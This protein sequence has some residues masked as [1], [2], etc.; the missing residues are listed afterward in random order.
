VCE[1]GKAYRNGPGGRG[2]KKEGE[3]MKFI[4]KIARGDGTF[5]DG[6]MGSK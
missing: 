6:V 1:A 2:S 5:G 3:K 4:L